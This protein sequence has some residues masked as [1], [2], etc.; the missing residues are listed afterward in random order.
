MRFVYGEQ[1]QRQIIQQRQTALGQ[2]SFGRQ[3]EQIEFALA[4]TAFDGL[5]LRPRHGRVEKR[6]SHT[7]FVQGS[8][9][10]LHQGDER[11]HHHGHAGAQQCRDL[12]AQ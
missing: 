7:R 2:Q 3:I 6:S 5:R 1:R 4:G 8:D 9:L 11:R 12:V 10:V